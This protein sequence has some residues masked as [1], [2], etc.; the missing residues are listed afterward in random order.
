VDIEE[1]WDVEEDAAELGKA[2]M[3]IGKQGV[4]LFKKEPQIENGVY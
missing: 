3:A 2:F 1:L 4:R